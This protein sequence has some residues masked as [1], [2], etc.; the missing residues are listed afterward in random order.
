MELKVIVKNPP[1]EERQK[2][3]INEIK[4][5][6]QINYYSQKG[7]IKMTETQKMFDIIH[8]NRRKVR[9]FNIKRAKKQKKQ[10]IIDDVVIFL[11]S[12]IFM[13]GIMTFIAIIESL[14]F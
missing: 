3:L 11:G 9:A 4:E 10:A 5:W 8:E 12:S 14:R 6:I 13:I 7:V 2:E 1:N